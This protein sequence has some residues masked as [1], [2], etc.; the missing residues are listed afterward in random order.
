M[1]GITGIFLRNAGD[2]LFEYI[3]K[4]NEC[5]SHRGPDDGDIFF[6][7]PVTFG[8][9]MLYTT[10]ESL[11][12]K[13]PFYD[14]EAGLIITADARIDNRDELSKLLDIKNEE[15]VPD[16]TFILYAYQKWGKKC[17]EYLLGDDL[18]VLSLSN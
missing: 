6:S 16:S 14:E 2:N 17:Q 5:L 9:Q 11:H 13:L 8:H 10:P 15:I 18:L 1:S 7:D 12:E 4:M 3:K